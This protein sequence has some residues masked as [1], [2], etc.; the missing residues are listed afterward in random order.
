MPLYVEAQLYEKAAS[1]SG[2]FEFMDKC[3]YKL[4]SDFYL[5]AARVGGPMSS[6]SSDRVR[7]LENTVPQQ[8]DYFFRGYKSGDV[9]KIDGP[10]YGWIKQSIIVK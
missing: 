6:S 3:V 10:S 7:A 2:S 5:K 8:E 1:Q 4:A 9:I